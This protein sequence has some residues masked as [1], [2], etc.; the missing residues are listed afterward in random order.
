QAVYDAQDLAKSQQEA[1]QDLLVQAVTQALG[2]VLSPSQMGSHYAALQTNILKQ[3]ERYVQ[4]YQIF[5]ENPA[6]GLYRITGQVAVAM[7]VLKRDV[8]KLGLTTSG[9]P[10]PQPIEPAAPEQTAQREEPA[11][12]PEPAQAPEPEPEPEPEPAQYR[13]QPEAP[14]QLSQSPEKK[15][16][17]AV[18]ENWDGT[19][20]LPGSSADPQSLFG[21][22]ALQETQDYLW[23]VDFPQTGALSVDP[24]GNLSRERLLALARSM[25]AQSIVTGSLIFHPGDGQRPLLKTSLEVIDVS[26]GQ[27]KG[28]VHKELEISY[29]HQEGA[30]RMAYEVVPQLDRLLRGTSSAVIPQSGVSVAAGD[31]WTLLVHSE[32]PYAS[33]EEL[34]EVLRGRFGSM[35][36]NKVEFGPNLAKIRIQGIG[37]ELLS[38]LQE[39][40]PLKDGARMQASGYSPENRSVELS[41]VRF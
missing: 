19:W 35:H 11:A 7:D 22:S 18:A 32:Y 8:R 34:E 10:Q 3:P 40:I 21:M 17:W 38:M 27:S 36:V 5:S 23:S 33:W 39:G 29:S 31:E 2:T 14:P 1:L 20:I 37:S 26:S 13:E 41:L 9:A 25:G 30:M 15:I 16:L 28:D 4:T 6:G 12:A 24:S